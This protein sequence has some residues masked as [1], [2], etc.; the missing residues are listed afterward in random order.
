MNSVKDVC[1]DFYTVDDAYE[2]NPEVIRELQLNHLNR[3]RTLASNA[4]YFVRAE[5]STFI[6]PNGL[7]HIDMAGGIGACSVGNNNEF[8]WNNLEKVYDHRNVMLGCVSINNL[9]AIFA[10]DMALL[11]PGGKLT[12][13]HTATGGGEAIEGAIKLVKIASRDKKDKTHIL[14]VINAFHGKTTGAVSVG[15][16][17]TWR[18]YQGTLLQNVD[19]V[20][21]ADEGALEAA[22]KT[23]KYIAFFIEPVQ[24]EAGIYPAPDSYLKKA[25]ELCTKYDTY[26]VCDEI[27]CGCAR[28]GK[29]W[30]CEWADVIPDVMPF[31]KGISGGMMPYAGYM[32]TEEIYEAAYGSPETCF[33]HTATYQ[34]NALCAAAGIASLQYILEND[35]CGQA[36]LKGDY[37]MAALK[38]IQQEYPNIV[39]EVRGRGL[40][41]GMEFMP[42]KKGLEAKYGDFYSIE[43]E[44]YIQDEYHIHVIHTLNNPAVY[45]F[46]PALNVS[47]EDIDFTIKAFGGAVKHVSQLA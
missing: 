1:K 16:K 21:F 23:G 44:R 45:R 33:H 27:Q 17:E 14:G 3:E 40:M 10:H 29:M 26:L 20:P 7:R 28:T 18:T 47:V 4:K 9:A 39:K 11:S 43:C 19:H 5:G 38:K 41:I 25:R 31:G 13:L 35:L 42:M 36:R 37:F 30:A 12:R 6:D 32:A 15:G 8:V 46:L 2:M 22:L 34:N 24:G